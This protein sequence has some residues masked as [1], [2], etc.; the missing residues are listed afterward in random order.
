MV[1][2]C[3]WDHKPQCKLP[4]PTRLRVRRICRIAIRLSL[5]RVTGCPLPRNAEYLLL[6]CLRCNFARRPPAPGRRTRRARSRLSTKSR[7]SLPGSGRLS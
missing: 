4:D 2:T 3:A 1:C 5:E 7:P 6:C